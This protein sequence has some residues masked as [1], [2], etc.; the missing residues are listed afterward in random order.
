M[1]VLK[2]ATAA[3][4][5]ADTSFIVLDRVWR[6]ITVICLFFLNFKCK[7][8]PVPLLASGQITSA[9]VFLRKTA[10]QSLIQYLKQTSCSE[11]TLWGYELVCIENKNKNKE[12]QS[13]AFFTKIHTS[14]RTH[15]AS[16]H[17]STH[18][19]GHPWGEG[20]M[21]KSAVIGPNNVCHGF[22]FSCIKLNNYG[23]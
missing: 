17:T 19:H 6:S 11:E 7:N 23:L 15:S 9:L 18:A 16:P 5:M 4:V 10:E 20:P 1:S 8:N 22:V 21:I 12:D 14:H 3:S 2:R 13:I